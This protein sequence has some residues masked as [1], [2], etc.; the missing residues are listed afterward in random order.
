M[1]TALRGARAAFVF[2]TRIPVGGFP[3]AADEWR[4]ASGWFPL[5][6]LV[7]GTACAALWMVAAPL[8]P[9]VAAI[10]VIAASIL[11]T[12]AFHED[13]LADTADAL[14][15]AY[16]RDRI[17]VILKDSRV[18]AFGAIALVVA[19]IFRL[20]LLAQLAEVSVEDHSAPFA[21]GP[22][23]PASAPVAAPPGLPVVP[24]A[25]ILAHCLARVGPVWLM[26]ALPYAT[27]PDAKGRE[28]ARATWPQ[29]ALATVLGVAV[30]AGIAFSSPEIGVGGATAAF[31]AMA[32]TTVVCGWRFHVR[33]GGVAGDF[34]G[35]A[36]QVGEVV[37]LLAVLAVAG[38][39]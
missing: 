33:A 35:A 25:L 21:S 26:V 30:A 24:A 29:G 27:G 9:W 2:L 1:K 36:E 31:A 5:V 8:G 16:D 20:V 11:A 22:S 15:G 19:I 37:I 10:I 32:A 18:G 13:G 23:S 34:L 17:F 3:F 7:L 28:V 12:G 4:W 14:G 38:V 39:A 6:G